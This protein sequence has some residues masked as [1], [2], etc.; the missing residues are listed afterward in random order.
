[1]AFLPFS[2]L[3]GPDSGIGWRPWSQTTVKENYSFKLKNGDT[4]T[5]KI[6][7]QNL[8]VKFASKN[9]QVKIASKNCKQNLQVKFEFKTK[10]TKNSKKFIKETIKYFKKFS[11]FFSKS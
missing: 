6:C 3:H 2:S 1:M 9:L 11:D 10:N 4:I 8:Q 7:K 5:S